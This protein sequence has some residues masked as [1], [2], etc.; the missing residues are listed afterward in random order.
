[1]VKIIKEDGSRDIVREFAMNTLMD[2]D[3]GLCKMYGKKMEN[4]FANKNF[5]VRFMS[6]Y[7]ELL[8]LVNMFED[9]I[10]LD[11]EA[12]SIEKNI[13]EAMDNK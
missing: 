13:K 12:T 9:D 4:A 6:V 1:M 7:V 11:K 8:K 2:I 5:F 10:E 3:M